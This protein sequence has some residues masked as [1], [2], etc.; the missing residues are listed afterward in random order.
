MNRIY[1]QKKRL[2]ILVNVAGVIFTINET[3]GKEKIFVK[4]DKIIQVN[5]YTALQYC[6][7]FLTHLPI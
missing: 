3:D 6:F 1:K 7:L 4:F 2:D 5:L